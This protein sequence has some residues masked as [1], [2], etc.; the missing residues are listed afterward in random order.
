LGGFLGL[1]GSLLGGGPDLL[2]LLLALGVVDDDVIG[3]GGL[4]SEATGGV[5]GQHNLDLD[6]HD[7]LLE[8]DVAGGDVEIVDLGLT[9]A[10]HVTL[11]ELHGLGALLLELAGDDD[12]TTLGVVHHD[13]L[14][15]GVGGESDG[16]I[17]EELE[18]QGL[19][20]GGGAE[21]LSLD[22][23]DGEFYGVLGVVEPLLDEEG[24]LSELSA[25]NTDD[26]EDLG[27]LDSDLGLDGSNSDLDAGVTSLLESLAEEGVEFGLENTVSH[28]LFLLV[29]SL[30]L[31]AHM[32]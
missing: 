15:D 3:D 23:L 30:D 28:E 11:L 12:L 10:D 31:L 8:E 24:E 5:E 14:D 32:I 1:L 18:L 13:G 4:D 9:G 27:G 26:G 20:L 25:L 2:L 29:D 19:D 17:L 7:A 6:S 16:D 22:A 21:T